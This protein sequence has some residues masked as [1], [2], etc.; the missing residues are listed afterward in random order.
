MSKLHDY[1]KSQENLITASVEGKTL[2][3]FIDRFIK[4]IYAFV[5]ENTVSEIW[6]YYN[7]TLFFKNMIFNF[8]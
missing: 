1:L 4:F 8:F 2:I 7:I 3:D 6:K 5:V